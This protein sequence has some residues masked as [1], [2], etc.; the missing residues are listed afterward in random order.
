MTVFDREY[1]DEEISLI[2]LSFLQIEQYS[3]FELLLIGVK[4]SLQYFMII[5]VNQ[6]ILRIFRLRRILIVDEIKKIR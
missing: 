4:Q 1:Y 5:V 3:S 2:F 6:D